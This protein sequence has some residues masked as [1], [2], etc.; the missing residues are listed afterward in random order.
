MVR[1]RMQ[2]LGR[3]NKPCYRI[4]V[5]DTRTK[6]Q[7]TY[8]ENV[9]TYDP[10]AQ[11]RAKQVKVLVE[12]VHAWVAK[13]AQMSDSVRQLVKRATKEAAAKPVAAKA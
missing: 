11:D 7:G 5:A 4:V 6:R 13:G 10:I 1:I 2:R 12:R 9:G 8:L 3:R